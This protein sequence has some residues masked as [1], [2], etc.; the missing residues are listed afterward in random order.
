MLPFSYVVEFQMV[1]RDGAIYFW[2]IH[3]FDRNLTIVGL[4]KIEE[5]QRYVEYYCYK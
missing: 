5:R 1:M 3:P 4:Q 2:W